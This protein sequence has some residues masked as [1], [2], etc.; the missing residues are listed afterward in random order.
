MSLIDRNRADRYFCKFIENSQRVIGKTKLILTRIIESSDAA[1]KKI[2]R[3]YADIPG[4]LTSANQ[5]LMGIGGEI[6]I[7]IFR[8]FI[9]KSM[10]FWEKIHSRD[11]TIL[12]DNLSLIFPN[13][14][15]VGKIQ[16]LYGA[17]NE[18]RCYV[19]ADEI[20]SIWKLIN[21][22]VH[23]CIKYIIF[24]HDEEF[25][26]KMDPDIVEKLNVNLET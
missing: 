4:T 9:R 2:A 22:L 7:N 19:K 12:T 13:N 6:Q 17:N 25:F 26:D 20:N 14:P 18:R 21:A 11:D 16:F 1:D 10:P 24:S 5:L 3:S 23:N 15:Y 8:T